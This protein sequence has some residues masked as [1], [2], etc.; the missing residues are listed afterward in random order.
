MTTSTIISDDSL[1]LVF[2]GK[3]M[4]SKF[5]YEIIFQNVDVP[6]HLS[7][8]TIWAN[9]KVEATKSA[10]EFAIRFINSKVVS[11]SR[12]SA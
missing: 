2:T 8:R 3:R 9:N 12:V 10:N 11:V 1:Q 5:Q 4:S 6:S 7:F